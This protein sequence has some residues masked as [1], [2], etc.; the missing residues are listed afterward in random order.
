MSSSRD[1]GFGATGITSNINAIMSK[2]AWNFV[3]QTHL[4]SDLYFVEK[5]VAACALTMPF[6][7]DKFSRVG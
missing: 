6:G 5:V 1:S 3:A 7:S 2:F 4:R